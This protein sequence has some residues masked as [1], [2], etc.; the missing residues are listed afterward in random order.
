MERAVHDFDLDVNDLVA[1]VNA[2]LDRFMN[3]VDDLGNEFLGNRAADDF[4]NHLHALAGFIRGHRDARVTVLTFTTGLA[5]ELAFAFG[6]FGNGFAIRDLRGTGVGFHLEF[7]LEA[8]NDDFQVQ[9]TH[10]RNDE[11]AGLFVGEATE[12][13]IFFRQAL[14]T[15]GQLVAVL[16]GLRFHGHADDRFREGRRFEGHVEVFVAQRIT[17]GDVAQ[18]DER[19]D[20]AGEH[21]VDVL[22]FAALNDHEAADAFAFARARIVDGVTFL[23]VAGVNTEEHQLAGVGIGPEL[24]R[25][26]AELGIVIHRHLDDDLGADFVTFRSGNVDRAWEIINDGVHE[27]LHGLLFEGGTAEHGHEFDFAGQAA[28][29]GLENG[30]RDRLFFQ[31][32]TGDFVVL[33]GDGVDQVGERGFGLFL[34]FRR[35]FLDLVIK[36]FVRFAGAPV[37][38]LLVDD[39]DDAFK[40]AGHGLA[41]GLGGT[42]P[43]GQEHRERIRL[44]LVAHVVERI[45]KI[46]AHAVHLVDERDTGD[47]V[48]GSLAPHGF[49]LRLH[50][51]HTAEY[52]HGT[53]QHAHGTFDFGREIHVAGSVDN[54]D[55]MRNVVERLVNGV[56]T[57]LAALLGPETGHGG[58]GDRDAAFLFLL[59]PV[60]HGI[61]VIDVTDLVDEAGVK[62]NTL[63]GGG[64][65]GINVRGNANVTGAF[66][67]IYACW[68]IDRFGV[69]HIKCLPLLAAVQYHSTSSN[70]KTASPRRT[71]GA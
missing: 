64:L 7:A 21:F 53:V 63:R 51:G 4:V 62:K 23:E 8:V 48:L 56:F 54:V 57:G 22:A 45:V 28:D 44:E 32:E 70:G 69:G 43:Q 6:R 59:H 71:N 14:E 11:L 20:V 25:E 52:G 10:A 15:F 41:F 55:A 24:E 36:T 5:D 40:T 34:V 42:L 27:H 58:G 2:A 12:G 66:E 37:N 35:D 38:D 18:T 30:G 13:R 39:V 61:A 3:A 9:F 17:G 31:H 65:A 50:A 67:R 29:G 68:R 49:G 33:V 26:R 60:S 46:R 19:G 1:G 16:L 47:V